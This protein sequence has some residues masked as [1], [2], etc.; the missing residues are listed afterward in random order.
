M[1]QNLLQWLYQTTFA[2]AVRETDFLF[3]AVESIHVVTFTMA[4]GSI[5][6][7]DLRLVGVASR[8]RPISALMDELLP[9]TWIAFG[10]AVLSGLVL[11]C[12]NATFY[13]ANVAFR[14]KMLLILLAGINMLMFHSVTY[15]NVEEWDVLPWPPRAAQLAGILSIALWIGTIAYGRWI[16]F[17]VH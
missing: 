12:S 14:M 10:L 9:L 2:T 1:I 11:F 4:V 6:F 17:A 5:L 15:R 7:V 8:N 13:Y 3:A 16:G